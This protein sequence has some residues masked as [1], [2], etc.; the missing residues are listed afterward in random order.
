MTEKLHKTGARWAVALFVFLIA[1]GLFWWAT[2]GSE[3]AASRVSSSKSP[4]VSENTARDGNLTND[5]SDLALPEAER[6]YIWEIEHRVLLLDFRFWP[7]LSGAM[8]AR[9]RPKVSSF[10]D[11]SASLGLLDSENVEP[12]SL[13]FCQL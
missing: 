11:S 9:D 1:A 4:T 8:R 12:E 13:G 6:N 7:V 2:H 5:G 3:L 10:F